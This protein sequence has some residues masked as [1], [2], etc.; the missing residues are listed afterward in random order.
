MHL[1]QQLHIGVS[2]PEVLSLSISNSFHSK[3]HPSSEIHEKH[4]FPTC[5]PSKPILAQE[6]FF[7]LL[8]KK[9]EIN[10]TL[11]K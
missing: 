10:Q 4:F 5:S 6:R 1:P 8:R 11:F 7:F 3:F 2:V 9:L